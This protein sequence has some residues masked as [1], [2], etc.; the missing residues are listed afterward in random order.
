MVVTGE[1]HFIN[2]AGAQTRHLHRRAIV[3]AF[4]MVE[5]AD[6]LG[7]SF[8]PSTFNTGADRQHHRAADGD[9]D[10][11]TGHA[12]ITVKFYFH[13]T[14]LS[15]AISISTSVSRRAKTSSEVTTKRWRKIPRLRSCL[16]PSTKIVCA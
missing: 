8:K 4:G 9:G 14:C 7:F 12:F 3:D 13:A 15:G 1:F 5:D 6:H 2:G 10:E 11:K 16:I